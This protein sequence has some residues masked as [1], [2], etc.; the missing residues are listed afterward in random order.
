MK[1]TWILITI[2]LFVI[3]ITFYFYGYLN[4]NFANDIILNE[5]SKKDTTSDNRGINQVTEQNKKY[6][7]GDNIQNSALYISEFLVPF[8]CSQP[9][10]LT[11]DKD[12][13]IWI[14]S[15][16]NGNIL[17]FNPQSNTFIKNIS[18]PN[19]HT[20]GMF[21]SMIWD[22]KFDKNGDLWFTDEQSNSIW[23]YFTKENKFEKY[24]SPTKNSYP[25][26][27][28]F[29]SNNRIWFTEVFGKKLGV[30]NPLEVKNNTS[31]GI[32]E[33]DLQKVV[34]FETTGPLSLGFK[35][36]INTNNNKSNNILWLSTVD[37]PFGGQIIKFDVSKEN[38]TVYNLNKTKSVPISVAEDEKGQAWTNDHASSLFV[39]L[40]PK[41]GYIQQFATSPATTRITPT[42]PYYNDFSEGKYW[43]NEHEGNAIAYY[44]PESKTLIEYH[45][46]TTNFNWGNTSNPLRFAIDNNGSVWFTEWTEN[47]IGVIKKEKMDKFPILI[48]VSKDKMIL[49]G[50][51][52]RGDSVDIFVN[53]NNM[54]NNQ[55]TL[56]EIPNEVINMFATSSI[57]KSGA[58]MESFKQI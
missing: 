31:N 19:W 26:S 34:K 38:F 49:D 27:L 45:I 33:F 37:F 22:L 43:F 47:K 28:A 11:V 52:G 50:K 8:P 12:N 20:E 24:K 56:T 46:P 35:N 6:V 39:M 7:C 42:L 16:W 23:K 30:L 54:S 41:T 15:V 3:A 58:T 17:V 51:T 25:S 18:I 13:N 2:G 14:A 32:K 21:G 57:S 36:A 40:D 29:D 5:N 53:R 55:Q 1:K 48:S 44:K 9:V 4:N 10:G